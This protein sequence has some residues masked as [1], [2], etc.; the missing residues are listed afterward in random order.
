MHQETAR[1]RRARCLARLA[2]LAAIGTL[3]C[4]TLPP[5][6][7]SQGV[8]PR[9]AA[10]RKLAVFPLR[11]SEAVLAQAA[12]AGTTASFAARIV[13]NALS[14]QILGQG[15]AVVTPGTITGAGLGGSE[16]EAPPVDPVTAAQE[17][18]RR[19]GASG[20]L[21]GTLQRWRDR[22][23]KPAAAATPASVAFSVTLYAAPSG[24][25]LWTGRFD[26]TQHAANERPLEAA[27]L[28]GKGS[29]WLSAEE[30][31]GF[32]AEEVAKALV[33]GK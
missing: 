21:L 18:T 3:A 33:A 31:A 23:G 20:V 11:P 25:R 6:V 26:Q 17:A 19:F 29:R 10:L 1:G 7:Q 5:V 14:Q 2:A 32:G 12:S 15:V 27:R 9:E 16:P 13:G 22:T 30:L 4:H 8:A 28:P 24:K